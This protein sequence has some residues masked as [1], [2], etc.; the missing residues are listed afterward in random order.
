MVGSSGHMNRREEIKWAGQEDQAKAYCVMESVSV[1][2]S[3]DILH[4]A[5]NKSTLINVLGKLVLY[6]DLS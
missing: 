2:S 5:R 6:S 4:R 3:P 1:I